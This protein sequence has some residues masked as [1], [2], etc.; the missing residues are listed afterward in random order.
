MPSVVLGGGRFPNIA[1]HWDVAAEA[2]EM[3]A[4]KAKAVPLTPLPLE[5]EEAPAASIA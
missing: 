5:I 2:A 3:L 1:L 4:Q